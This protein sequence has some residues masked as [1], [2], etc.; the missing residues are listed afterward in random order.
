MPQ[1]LQ[2]H[3]TLLGSEQIQMGRQ[4]FH[5]L[6]KVRDRKAQFRNEGSTEQR[7]GLEQADPSS[8]SP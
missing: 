5:I 6:E 1:V 3:L 8:K 7:D 2:A 4:Q